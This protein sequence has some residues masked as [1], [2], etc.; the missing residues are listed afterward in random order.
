MGNREVREKGPSS[1]GFN[2]DEAN[3][4]FGVVNLW[5]DSIFVEYCSYVSRVWEFGKNWAKRVAEKG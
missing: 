2:R 5:F 4:R 3:S 1:L